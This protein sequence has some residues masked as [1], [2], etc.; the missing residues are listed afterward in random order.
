MLDVVEACARVLAPHGSLVFELGDT[1]AS[2]GGITDN[3]AVSLG[4]N[5]FA[6]RPERGGGKGWPLD[7]SKVLIPQLFAIALAYGFNPLT[8]RKTEPWRVRNTVAWARPNP[9]VG[10]DGDK[11]RPAT[12]F[13]TVACK[14]R[15]RYWDG[16][17]VRTERP[18]A[19][20]SRGGGLHDHADDAVKGRA[21]GAGIRPQHGDVTNPAGA[22]LLDW[23]SIPTQP[24]KGA[25][26]ATFPDAL[27]VPVVKAMCPRR[28]CRVCGEP[29]RRITE[30]EAV[31]DDGRPVTA[32]HK[33]IKRG[34]DVGSESVPHG[35]NAKFRRVLDESWT[36]CGHGDDWR[37]GHVLDPFGGSGTTGLVAMGHGL[38][39]TM[40]DI[41]ERNAEL[42]YER[43]G[44]MFLTI[45]HLK[46]SE[47]V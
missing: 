10:R 19:A 37:P 14:A 25:H 24:Y 11:F 41:D 42:A 43:I 21:Q 40:I 35:S 2:A 9:P 17:A 32:E 36:S 27:V 38:D 45:E 16:D 15:D 8:G 1:Y 33:S 13:L 18:D 26:Y 7:K 47:I 22:P 3:R 46:P 23:W 31:Y 29:S 20:V 28:V 6:P 30:S 12:S 4:G 44:G 34:V 5:D 39:A